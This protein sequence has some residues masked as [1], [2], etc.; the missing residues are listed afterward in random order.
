LA[1]SATVERVCRGRV[2][3]P[4]ASRRDAVQGVRGR[5][6]DH[7]LCRGGAPPLALRTGPLAWSPWRI[8][9]CASR[10]P[11]TTPCRRI[12]IPRLRPPGAMRHVR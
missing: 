12:P 6:R 8:A 5:R 2:R 7:P 4:P 9:S 1:P 10:T 11:T 3:Q